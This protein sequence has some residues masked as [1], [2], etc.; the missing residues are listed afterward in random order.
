MVILSILLLCDCVIVQVGGSIVCSV[1][2]CG[3]VGSSSLI[4]IVVCIWW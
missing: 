3:I 1:L 2:V 4:R